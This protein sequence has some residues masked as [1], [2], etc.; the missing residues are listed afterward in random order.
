[1]SEILATDKYADIP[2]PGFAILC[3]GYLPT[4]LVGAPPLH[5]PSLHIIGESDKDVPV[6]QARSLQSLFLDPTEYLHDQGHIVPQR[7][8]DADAIIKWLRAWSKSQD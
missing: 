3:A 4:A 2:A 5:V 8:L 1:M 6:E 7:A